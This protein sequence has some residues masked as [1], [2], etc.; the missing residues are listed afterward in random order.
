VIVNFAKSQEHLLKGQR[1]LDEWETLQPNLSEGNR[2]AQERL[3]DLLAFK[4]K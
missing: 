4:K 3:D 1:F 2:E